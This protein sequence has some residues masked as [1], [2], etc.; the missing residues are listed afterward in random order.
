MIPRL[1]KRYRE[2][3]VPEMLRSL[4]FTNRLQVPKLVKVVVNMGI[5]EGAEDFK[6]LESA[7]SELAQITGQRP[8]ITRAKKAVSNFKIRKY[9]PVGCKV[10]LRKAR[11]Y[12]F[13]DRLINVALPSLKDFR[14]V[15]PESFDNYGN[16]SLGL[17]EQ[18]IFPEIDY[19]KVHKVHGM[20]ITIV[21]NTRSK[22]E[23]LLL[24]KL[25]GMPFKN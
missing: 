17:T 5:G 14:G 4:N 24:L 19:D 10:T 7:V 2:E 3:I 1:H 22:K 21:T 18:T 23:A 6:L 16:Y 9:S 13:L 8:V 20:D 12:E 25:I 11:M 15:S